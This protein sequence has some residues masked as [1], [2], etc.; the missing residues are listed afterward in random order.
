MIIGDIVRVDTW[1]DEINPETGYIWGWAVGD[2][3]VTDIREKEIIVFFH[4]F[5]ANISVPV[6]KVKVVTTQRK[7][8]VWWNSLSINEQNVFFQKHYPLSRD[9]FNYHLVKNV[10]EI[11]VAEDGPEPNVL[12]PIDPKFLQGVL[13]RVG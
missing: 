8:M 3:T 6:E 2:G 12:I 4:R 9:I 7:A 10:T 1:V 11:Y 13:Q 5:G